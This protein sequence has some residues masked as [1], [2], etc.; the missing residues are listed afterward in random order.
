MIEGLPILTAAEMR[1]AE[2]ATIAD[3]VSVETLMARAG[4]GV[5]AWVRR[6][7]GA[8]VLILCGPGNNGGDGYVA[9]RWLRA[10]GQAVR[11]AASAPPTTE[12]ARA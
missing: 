10:R 6:L 4:E 11:V 1:A 3:G 12:A 5:G 8:E 9:A 7:S 2:A